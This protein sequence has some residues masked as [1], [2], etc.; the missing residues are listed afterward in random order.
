[1]FRLGNSE[2]EGTFFMVFLII[3]S[4]LVFALKIITEIFVIINSHESVCCS[5]KLGNL[6]VSVIGID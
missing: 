4:G 1:M 3:F 6:K 5:V 2:L